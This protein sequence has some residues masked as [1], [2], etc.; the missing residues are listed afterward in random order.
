ME[1]GEEDSKTEKK[2][3]EP[4]KSVEEKEVD[5]R[6][7]SFLSFNIYVP[8]KPTSVSTGGT[9]SPDSDDDSEKTATK[10]SPSHDTTEKDEA[11]AV[12]EN[13]LQHA[14]TESEASTSANISDHVF[15][16]TSQASFRGGAG[17]LNVRK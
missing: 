13:N 3:R 2:T 5:A 16:F 12:I 7:K 14:E 17:R 15:S 1:E 10:D 9:G 6:L 11:P 4:K 8:R